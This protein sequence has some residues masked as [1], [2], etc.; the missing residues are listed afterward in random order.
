MCICTYA[1]VISEMIDNK[2]TRDW[3]EE[4][5]LFLLEGTYTTH[6]VPCCYLKVDFINCKCT[7]QSIKIVS[8]YS[9]TT[10]KKEK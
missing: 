9:R 5:G 4:L 8:V 1:Y 2:D 10:T 3:R 7:L 6:E